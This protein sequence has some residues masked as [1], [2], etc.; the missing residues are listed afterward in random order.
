M[1]NDSLNLEHLL[2]A[3]TESI[4]D[5][6]AKKLSDKITK[7]ET[8][9][10]NDNEFLGTEDAMVFLKIKSRVTLRNYIKSGQIPQPIKAGGRKLIFKKSDLINFLSYGK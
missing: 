5:S 9:L 2:N 3:L 4:S 10:S 8:N 6:V 7:A 1:N